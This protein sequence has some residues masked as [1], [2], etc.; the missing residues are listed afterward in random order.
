MAR[1]NSTTDRHAAAAATA[2]GMTTLLSPLLPPGLSGALEWAGAGVAAALAARALSL[3]LEPGQSLAQALRARLK[4]PAGADAS[5]MLLRVACGLDRPTT[6]LGR[7]LQAAV[8]AGAAAV[9]LRCARPL[10]SQAAPLVFWAP[11]IVQAG[12]RARLAHELVESLA[13]PAPGAARPT[14]RLVP[15]PAQAVAPAG[16][17]TSASRAA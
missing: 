10:F 6:A 4:R 13:A 11:Q 7:V 8:P 14:L 5:L 17:F 16:T 12:L 3:Q 2:V 15:R 1:A 9:G